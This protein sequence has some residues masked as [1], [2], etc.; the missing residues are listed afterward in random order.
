MKVSCLLFI[1]S[2]LPILAQDPVAFAYQDLSLKDIL[3][4]EITTATKTP[5][6]FMHVPGIVSIM[7]RDDIR[8]TG[9]R[10]LYQVLEHVNAFY[11]TGS[12]FFPNNT[13]AIRG[14]L[15]NHADNHVLLLLNGRPLLESYSG[16]VNFPIYKSFP[17]S[18][19]DRLEIIRGPGSVLYGTNAFVG[20][21]NIVTNTL[22]TA[23]RGVGLSRGRYDATGSELYYGKMFGDFRWQFSSQTYEDRGWELTGFDNQNDF[24]SRRLAEENV[25]IYT[26]ISDGNLS[27]QY[28]H[29]SSKIGIVGS[30]FDWQGP[31]PPDRRDMDGA[32]DFLDISY[33]NRINNLRY[34]FNLDYGHMS[35]EQYNYK[36]YSQDLYGD[37]LLEYDHNKDLEWVAGVTYWRREVGSTPRLSPAPVPNFHA[38]WWNAFIQ[39]DYS[40]NRNIKLILGAQINKA[41]NLDEHWVTRAGGVY[42]RGR[43]A[44]KT[45]YSEAY[46]SAFAVETDFNI[47]IRGEDGEIRGGL[48]GNPDLMP[49]TIRTLDAQFAFSGE[50]LFLSFSVFDSDED[51]LIIRERAPDRVIDFLNGGRLETQ[52]WELDGRLMTDGPLAFHWGYAFQEN[53]NAEGVDNVTFAP[54]HMAKVGLTYR[55]LGFRASLNDNW[56]SHAFATG[57]ERNPNPDAYHLVTGELFIEPYLLGLPPWS[58]HWTMRL[59]GYNLLDEDI[60]HPEFAGRG[61]NSIPARGGR[62]LTFHINFAF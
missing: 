15:L 1:G 28:L 22:Q 6:T 13:M 51:D 52:G 11:P 55:G 17:L 32:R 47:I 45:Q 39:S 10:D 20:V 4:L 37:F 54:Q 5:R 2:F 8:R 26:S 60:Y 50:S 56:Y 36:A 9:A 53:H 42:T 41:E 62:A 48:R 18:C 44:V 27:L 59:T 23:P 49:E 14:N 61:V 57:T 35:F 58:R 12:F 46:R 30:T 19:I 3:N 31:V 38:Y 25:G 43:F 34:K 40:I 21:I 24:G 7:T 29:A 33:Q 16:G